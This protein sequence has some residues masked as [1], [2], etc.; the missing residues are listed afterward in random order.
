MAQGLAADGYTIVGISDADSDQYSQSWLLTRGDGASPTEMAL[1]R[2]FGITA[3]RVRIEPAL[4]EADMMLILG[5]DAT[6][7]IAGRPATPAQ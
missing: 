2:Q 6:Q 1:E 5:S 4:P 3:S 7:A